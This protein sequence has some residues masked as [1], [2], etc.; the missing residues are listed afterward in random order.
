MSNIYISSGIVNACLS[1]NLK[2]A[3]HKGYFNTSQDGRVDKERMV[4]TFA[5]K[6]APQFGR[7]NSGPWHLGGSAGSQEVGFHAIMIHP[8][9][10]RFFGS[11][12]TIQSLCN[13]VHGRA[14]YDGGP[15]TRQSLHPGP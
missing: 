5:F 10:K 14:I 11:A 4:A 3:L 15:E 1:V 13:R 9:W 12:I 2:A 8:S 6:F 7:L